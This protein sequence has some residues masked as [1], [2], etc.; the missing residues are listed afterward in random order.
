[1]IGYIWSYLKMSM[2]S[3]L[4]PGQKLYLRLGVCFPSTC[5]ASDVKLIMGSEC[6]VIANL[7]SRIDFE[8]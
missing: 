1:M 4:Q 7:N 5:G 6:F 2:I 3:H 8:N